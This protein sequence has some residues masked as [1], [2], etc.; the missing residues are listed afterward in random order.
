MEIAAIILSIIALIPFCAYLW[1]RWFYSPKIII[2]VGGDQQSIEV[3]QVPESGNVPFGISMGSKLKAFVSEVWVGFNDE[4][5]DLHKTKGGER[6][7]TTDSQFPMAVLFPERRA[8]KQGYLQTNYF[9]YKQRADNFSVKITVRAETDEAELPFLL[10]M[11][12]AP[13]V[14]AERVVKFKV[15]KGMIN[16]LKRLGLT[17]LPGESI[18]SEGIQSQEAFWAVTDRDVAQVKAREIIED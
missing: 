4:E 1:L 16:D 7:I 2:R 18:Q 6:R 15:V 11:F 13:K 9:D 12:P 3:M 8:V 14:I 17:M 10:N 5:V